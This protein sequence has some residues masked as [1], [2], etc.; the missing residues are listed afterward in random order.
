MLIFPRRIPKKHAPWCGREE[1][2]FACLVPLSCCAQLVVRSPKIENFFPGKISTGAVAIRSL[3]S[4][5]R[6]RMVDG[7]TVGVCVWAGCCRAATR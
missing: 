2:P 5:K 7:P 6:C 1:T 3:R 4:Q